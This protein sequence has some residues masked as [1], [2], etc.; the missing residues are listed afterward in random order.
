MIIHNQS[1]DKAS[2]YAME[3]MS[4][5]M[6]AEYHHLDSSL[7]DLLDQ[8]KTDLGADPSLHESIKLEMQ[9]IFLSRINALPFPFN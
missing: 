6:N 8:L 5:V 1:I 7:S 3:I 2:F 4:Q 9:R